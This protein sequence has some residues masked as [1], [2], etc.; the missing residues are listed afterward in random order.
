MIIIVNNTNRYRYSFFALYALI[1]MGNAAYNTFIPLYLS[2]IGFTKGTIGALL[3]LG[4]FITIFA[5]P[6][7]GMAGDRA[8]TK[9]FILKILLFG[10]AVA[11]A[12]YSV[13][14]SLYYLVLIMSLFVF[15]QSSVGPISDSITLEYLDE[16]KWKFGPIRMAGTIGYALMSIVAGILAKR[17]VANIFILYFFI[18]LAA[19]VMVFNLPSI[20]GHQAHGKKVSPF[21]LF[22]HKE[23]MLFF[24]FNLIMQIVLGFYY[25]F[26]SI[27]FQQLGGDTGL[28]GWAMFLS[29][30]SEIPFLL[31]A[32][33]IIR[34]I[35]FRYTLLAAAV[36]LSLRMLFIGLTSSLAVILLLMLMHGLTF[37]VLTFS[38]ATYINS[39]VPK[40]L[41]A[42]GQALNALICLGLARIVG[43]V[44]GGFLS[45]IYGISRVFVMDSILGFITVAVFSFI[46]L[47]KNDVQREN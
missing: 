27:Y 46:F 19:F 29:S 37:I 6:F 16:T 21:I 42:S 13:S 1:F 8:N 25:S 23:L 2:N 39:E 5:Q 18:A 14:T 44:A 35:G 10:S 4:P 7:W 31:F 15:L 47:K 41:K 36:V 17:N 28:L 38:M 3:A 32:D 34:K 45:D 12:L 40:E 9:N 24:I 22:R 33:R 11:V 26:F 43:S 30:T 20:K